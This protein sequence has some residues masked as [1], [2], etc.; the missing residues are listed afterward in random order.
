MFLTLV[1]CHTCREKISA[2]QFLF[3]YFPTWKYGAIVLSSSSFV[4]QTLTGDTTKRRDLRQVTRNSWS[5]RWRRR[6]WS[7]GKRRRFRWRAD[8]GWA[9]WS[10]WAGNRCRCTARPGNDAASTVLAWCSMRRDSRKPRPRPT[11]RTP[12]R[13]TPG[14]PQAAKTPICVAD[15]PRRPAPRWRTPRRLRHKCSFFDFL[16]QH[17]FFSKKKTRAPLRAVHISRVKSPVIKQ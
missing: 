15:S 13:P 10:R 1:I 4:D 8:S 7:P 12:R 11:L 2:A 16:C 17:V 14:R 3:A 5:C 6:D 9:V